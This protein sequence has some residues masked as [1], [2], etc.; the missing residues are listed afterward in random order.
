MNIL[1]AILLLLMLP[2]GVALIKKNRLQIF[3]VVM[4][5]LITTAIFLSIAAD[6]PKQFANVFLTHQYAIMIPV[7][8]NA[9]LLALDIV[10][11]FKPKQAITLTPLRF[12]TL[13]LY[14]NFALVVIMA[15]DNNIIL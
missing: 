15:L 2:A 13:A 6:S 4:L 5:S 9:Q 3:Y 1:F 14:A 7:I 8:I 11:Y 12:I 10:N